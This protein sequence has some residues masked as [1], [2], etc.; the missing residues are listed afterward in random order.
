MGLPIPAPAPFP[1]GPALV[2]IATGAGVPFGIVY[3]AWLTRLAV[4]PSSV[5]RWIPVAALALGTILPFFTCI[6]FV[7]AVFGQR[8]KA[9]ATA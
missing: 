4:S 3:L 2:C 8:R 5:S 1:A 6:G 7:G 9:K